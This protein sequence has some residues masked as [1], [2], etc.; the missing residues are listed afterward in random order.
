VN[1]AN[2]LNNINGGPFA[3]IAMSG[4]AGISQA[5]PQLAAFL[6]ANL[7][8]AGRAAFATAATQCNSA[9]VS[10]FAFTDVYRYFTSADPLSQPVPSQVLADDTL[11]QHT[12]TAPLFVYQSV[13][14]E[15]IPPADVDAVVQR[16]CAQGATVTYQRDI[17]SEHIAL[18]VTGAPDALN[19][20]SAR[21][22]GTPTAGG[23]HTSTVAT[24]LLSPGALTTLGPLLFNDF[25]ALLGRP[26]GPGDMA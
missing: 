5:Y 19:W 15:L 23:C 24:S 12:P 11:G 17:L 14:D 8:P 4:I 16:Y 25:L 20:L 10:T 26:I 9:N 1:P 2:V 13:H 3:G 6:A 18:V 21:L 22:A 7:T